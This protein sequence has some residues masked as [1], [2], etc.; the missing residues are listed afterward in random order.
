MSCGCAVESGGGL[1]VS[2]RVLCECEMLCLS[3]IVSGLRTRSRVPSPLPSVH[4]SGGGTS[5]LH[6]TKH[7]PSLGVWEVQYVVLYYEYRYCRFEEQI[8]LDISRAV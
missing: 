1:D 4:A 8:A 6:T 3:I 2:V 5:T 7:D